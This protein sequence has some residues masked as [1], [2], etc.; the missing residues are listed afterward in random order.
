MHGHPICLG[1]WWQVFS[2]FVDSMKALPGTL[3]MTPLLPRGRYL[4]R[5]IRRQTIAQ[6]QGGGTEL[7]FSVS[8]GEFAGQL[9]STRLWAAGKVER[10][11][12][13]DRRVEMEIVVAHRIIAGGR[14]IATVH[15]FKPFTA[16]TAADAVRGEDAATQRPPCSS[17]PIAPDVFRP[18]PLVTD[19]RLDVALHPDASARDEDPG[20]PLL[21]DQ[22]AM[23]VMARAS[24]DWGP[25]NL[26]ADEVPDYLEAEDDVQ[27]YGWGVS[28]LGQAIASAVRLASTHVALPLPVAADSVNEQAWGSPFRY[29]ADLPSY[30]SA[31][32][33]SVR[34]YSG[35]AWSCWL[36]IRLPLYDTF[37]R[38]HEMARM[39]ALA[40]ARL[41]L[42]C[43]QIIALNCWSESIALFIPSCAVEAVPQV[44][45]EKVAGHFAQVLSDLACLPVGNTRVRGDFPEL[46]PYDN[47]PTQ[48]V[49][50]DRRLY[51][52]VAV[53][54]A[55]NSPD[56]CGKRFA[57]TVSYEELVG[58]STAGVEELARSPREVRMPTWRA[59]AV[60]DLVTLWDYAIEAEERR[61]NRYAS[62]V[63]DEDFVHAD[64]FD[65]LHHGTDPE[66][67]PKRLFRAARNLI[68]LG[69]PRDAAAKLLHPG[70][71]LSSLSSSELEWGVENAAQ[72]LVPEGFYPDDE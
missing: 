22:T 15:D 55:F 21:I 40:C 26:T 53:L 60:G 63:C 50:I 39:I 70:A 62:L 68:K 45:Y 19:F 6:D 34:G 8:K 27:V 67:A 9:V 51:G 59:H 48:H 32:H 56:R 47:N 4:A 33:Q 65:F 37:D 72:S 66:S 49:R 69:V 2:D 71:H 18:H 31:H 11:D 28:R 12:L 57:V 38:T 36:P 3:F 23:S 7:T 61:S 58:L 64:T 35:H 25:V 29:T 30:M 14:R 17:S 54:P 44:G 1:G 10:A 24:D 41:G 52:P 43:D 42:P 46:E 5:L 20:Y 16:L 13:L